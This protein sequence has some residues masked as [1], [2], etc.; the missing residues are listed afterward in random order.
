MAQKGCCPTQERGDP[1]TTTVAYGEG[2]AHVYRYLKSVPAK[3]LG[4]LRQS[5]RLQVLIYP[6]PSDTRSEHQLQLAVRRTRT[7]SGVSTKGQSAAGRG[8]ELAH[9]PYCSPN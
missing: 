6:H 4:E 7:D 9:C 8:S 1:I 3:I 2:S 5:A